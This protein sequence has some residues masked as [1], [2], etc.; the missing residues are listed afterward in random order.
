MDASS[1]GNPAPAPQAGR[2]A[3]SD[4]FKTGYAERPSNRGQSSTHAERESS[5]PHHVP[6][7]LP[8][9]SRR[10]T[11]HGPADRA[12]M[13]PA[14]S[15]ISSA[16]VG[17]IRFCMPHDA[18]AAGSVSGGG[19]PEGIRQGPREF[20]TETLEC[21]TTRCG[22]A[23]IEPDHLCYA[24]PPKSIWPAE[25]ATRFRVEPD[26]CIV[27]GSADAQSSTCGAERA[28]GQTATSPRCAI[29]GTP[30]TALLGL[31]HHDVPPGCGAL[32]RCPRNVRVNGTARVRMAA[33]DHTRFQRCS[34]HT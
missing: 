18:I 23:S 20:R 21:H 5:L 28:H 11:T 3:R 10:P 4:A 31:I 2:Q 30:E 13:L 26:Q 29:D 1:F 27:D 24:A 12:R 14:L 19:W 22:A 9:R 7:Q 32:G 16:R 8:T 34:P 17:R 33:G 15:S 25:G 6:D